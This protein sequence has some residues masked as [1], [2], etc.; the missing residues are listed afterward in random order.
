MARRKLILSRHGFLCCR[1]S[2]THCVNLKEDDECRNLFPKGSFR[3]SYRRGYKN[4]KEW[5]APSKITLPD[6]CEETGSSR[7]QYHGKCVKCGV[8]VNML[9][10]GND[11]QVYIYT[12]QVLEENIEFKS[13]QTGERYKIRQD[14]DCK[15]DNI[16]YL[17]TC[18][19]M[20]VSRGRIMLKTVTK[21]FELHHKY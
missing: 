14:I 18:K 20:W 5:I 16:I 1:I 2:I 13:A 11:A 15:S 19:K 10:V 21:S 17:V 12:C 7:R 6:D 8:V 9:E 4:L 3:V